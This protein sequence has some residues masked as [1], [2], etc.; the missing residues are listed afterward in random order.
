M[1][2]RLVA[3]FLLAGLLSL[4]AASWTEALRAMPLGPGT[5]PI[6]RD[7]AVSTLFEAFRSN[8]VVKGVLV[9]PEVADDFYLIHRDAPKLN[10]RRTNLLEALVA[11]TNATA[12]R[13][14]WK[15]PFVLLHLAGDTLSPGMRVEHPATEDWL[16]RDTKF[17]AAH[18]VDVHWERL[19]PRLAAGL[20]CR[21]RPEAASTDAWHFARHNFVGWGLSGW[22][23]LEAASLTGNTTVIIQNRAIRVENRARR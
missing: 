19:Q 10:L 2:F 6:N 13:L 9:L 16:R 3:G 5:P 23:V 14:T 21:V 11:L 15:E 1:N 12:L 8:A 7:N 18:F 17:P 20:G 22:E 4:P